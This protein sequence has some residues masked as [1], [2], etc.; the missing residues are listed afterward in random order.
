MN[1]GGELFAG[2]YSKEAPYAKAPTKLTD[3]EFPT[4]DLWYDIK[5]D[6]IGEF[7]CIYA[8]LQF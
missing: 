3:F 7:T 4:S 2:E 6:R 5:A 1:C 8:F